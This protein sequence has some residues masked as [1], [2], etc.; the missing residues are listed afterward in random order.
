M[1]QP[2]TS[3]AALALGVVGVISGAAPSL[4]SPITYTETAT[5]SG[6]LGAIGTG[7]TFTCPA[8][9]AFTNAT[10]TLT[11]NNVTTTVI[12]TPPGAPTLYENFGTATV[13]VNGGAPVTFTD[14]K[15]EVFSAQSPPPITVGFSDVTLGIDILD[16]S[17]I[18]FAGYALA[19]SIVPTSGNPAFTSLGEVFPTTG[20]GFVLTD[21]PLNTSTFT[22]TTPAA[23]PEP[24]SLALLGMALAGLGAIRRRKIS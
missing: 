17:S 14:P 19:T 5:A 22:A 11:M 18:S 24:S 1:R 12:G 2:T 23:A 4:S 6:C 8:G 7:S 10:V 13:S 20:R 9:D 3:L 15:I 16:D 21:V